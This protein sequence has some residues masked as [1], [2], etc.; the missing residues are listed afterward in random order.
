MSS[1]AGKAFA[2]DARQRLADAARHLADAVLTSEGATDEELLAA[3]DRIEQVADELHG[4]AAPGMRPVGR[5]QREE[6]HFD[7]LLRSPIVGD[8]NPLAPP[9]AWSHED[10]RV[11][12]TGLFGAAYEGPPGYVHGGWIALGFDE[13]L[14]MANIKNKTPGMTGRL[15]IR[16][17]RPTPLLTLVRFEA[18]TERV[19][20]RR[21]T[22]CGTLDAGDERLATAEGLFVTITPE[23]AGKYFGAGGR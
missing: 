14:G 18:W 2:T 1:P 13:V 5:R 8:V 19:E 3:T 7:F 6:G 21:I 16:Y 23:I 20:G 4:R 10:D 17:R 22:C 12:A 11:V 9:F 15:S